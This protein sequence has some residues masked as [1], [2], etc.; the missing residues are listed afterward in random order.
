MLQLWT[1]Q[2]VFVD[3]MEIIKITHHIIILTRIKF[4]TINISFQVIIRLWINDSVVIYVVSF[5]TIVHG[6]RK[7][8]RIMWMGSISNFQNVGFQI[9]LPS[10]SWKVN[11]FLTGMTVFLED[12]TIRSNSQPQSG[13]HPYMV[14]VR[15]NP[16]EV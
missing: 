1:I 4:G 8:K 14:T 7:G 3:D 2:R 12:D 11:G 15:E 5:P 13:V 9:N 10:V 6:K 16:S